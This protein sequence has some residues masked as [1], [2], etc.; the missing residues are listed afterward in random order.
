MVSSFTSIGIDTSIETE[1]QKDKFNFWDETE[2]YTSYWILFSSESDTR[3]S[4]FKT[5]KSVSLERL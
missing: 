5:I 4:N 3:F 1:E 2:L